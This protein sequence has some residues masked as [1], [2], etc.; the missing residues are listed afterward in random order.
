MDLPLRGESILRNLTFMKVCGSPPLGGIH[1]QK[2]HFYGGVRISP[3]GGNPFRKSLFCCCGG[4]WISFGGN[5]FSEISLLWRRADLPL[6][7]E[8]VFL[9]LTFMEVFGSPRLGNPF[10]EISLLL[11]RITKSH[12]YGGVQISP[13]GGNPFSEISLFWRCADL[14][15]GGSHFQKSHLQKSQETQGALAQHRWFLGISL[16]CKEDVASSK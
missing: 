11:H 2:S 13:F 15:F 1:F 3:F 16:H 10:S 4:V 6:R 9:N 12:I 14:P 7:G 8:S 5:P